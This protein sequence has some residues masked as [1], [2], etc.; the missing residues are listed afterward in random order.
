MYIRKYKNTKDVF[1]NILEELYEESCQEYFR[2]VEK[3]SDCFEIKRDMIK[4]QTYASFIE[5]YVNS[6]LDLDYI[7]TPTQIIEKLKEIKTIAILPKKYRFK[8]IINHNNNLKVNPLSSD[9]KNRIYL[10]KEF[11]NI[12][13]KTWINDID[14]YYKK[15]DDKGFITADNQ[16]QEKYYVK[17]GFKFLDDATS[18]DTAENINCFLKNEERPKFEEKID[19]SL[20]NGEPYYS[21]FHIKGEIQEPAIYFSDTMTMSSK[22]SLKKVSTY[23]FSDN[24]IRQVDSH[25]SNDETKENTLYNMLLCMGRLNEASDEASGI[26]M[27][28]NSLENSK[29]YLDNLVDLANKSM[30]KFKK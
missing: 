11:G 4:I 15:I 24:F 19:D 23:A 27:S 29:V 26:S 14:F 21:N 6:L 16:K 30:I 28:K 25:Y 1:Y 5:E 9:E 10:F 7:E 13:H 22:D 20:F 18:I 2:S 12:I 3:E 17:E 8:T